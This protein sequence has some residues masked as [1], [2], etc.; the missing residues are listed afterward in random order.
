MALTC[1]AAL[2]PYKAIERQL[3]LQHDCLQEPSQFTTLLHCL[4]CR[5]AA[6]PAFKALL[7][8]AQRYQP[9]PPLPR[10]QPRDQNEAG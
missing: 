8:E 6:V 10:E 4:L 9:G 1:H 7:D 3:F 5:A 2:P